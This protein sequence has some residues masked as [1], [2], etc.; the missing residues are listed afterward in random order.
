MAKKEM[1]NKETG[2]IRSISES[3]FNKLIVTESINGAGTLRVQFDYSNCPTMAEQHTAHLS[4]INYLMEKMQPDALAQYIAARNSHRVPIEGHDFTK[5]PSLQDGLNAVYLAK[6]N[7]FNL[8]EDLQS[9]FRSPL[10]F[11]KFIDNPANQEKMIK[12][13]ILTKK[14]VQ[15]LTTTQEEDK[16]KPSP[17]EDP[18]TESNKN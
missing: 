3:D 16:N 10:E 2:E 11:Y 18:K 12:M 14:E 5:E 6:Q 9:Q 4:D 1:V 13:G 8:P 17:K 15:T 7:F